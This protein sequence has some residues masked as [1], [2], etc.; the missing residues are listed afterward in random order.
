MIRIFESFNWI[1]WSELCRPK[2]FLLRSVHILGKGKNSKR[3]LKAVRLLKFFW[4]EPYSEWIII[5]LVIFHFKLCFEHCGCHRVTDYLSWVS[6][7][8]CPQI[9]R[10][11]FLRLVKKIFFCCWEGSVFWEMA[12][13][14][15]E[16]LD[17]FHI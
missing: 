17:H 5:K 13:Q 9:K 3:W 4:R 2:V 15:S 1:V 12:G 16:G 10:S 6:K 11:L 8:C 7:A 14:H